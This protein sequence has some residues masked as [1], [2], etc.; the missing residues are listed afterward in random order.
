M[1]ELLGITVAE[2]DRL[3]RAGQVTGHAAAGSGFFSLKWEYDSGAIREFDARKRGKGEEQDV[4]SS[5]LARTANAILVKA[6][7]SGA[8]GI[9]IQR[10]RTGKCVK[11]RNAG[12]LR[13]VMGIPDASLKSLIRRYL[14][15]AGVDNPLE[16]G[17]PR[18][19]KIP[20][21]WREKPYTVIAY[22]LPTMR[23]TKLVLNIFSE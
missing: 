21:R 16:L 6:F 7:E 22:S 8:S 12:V 13:D 3:R 11:C 17:V 1:A 15:M 18:Q 23:G 2:L 9:V 20:V 14:M 4:A 19:G 10:D 5:E